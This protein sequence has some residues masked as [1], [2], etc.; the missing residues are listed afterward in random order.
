MRGSGSARRGGGGE[1]GDGEDG[2]GEQ[3][4][5]DEEGGLGGATVGG[6]RIA[7]EVAD[8]HQRHP[9]AGGADEQSGAAGPW[10]EAAGDEGE[11]GAMRK[12]PAAGSRDIGQHEQP[13]QPDRGNDHVHQIDDRR[14]D[15]AD[16]DLES[17]ISDF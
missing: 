13:A 15:A 14:D 12:V 8:L 10:D 2:E 6:V 17:P 4:E 11:L 5:L 1:Q 7:G 16:S 9:G 3:T